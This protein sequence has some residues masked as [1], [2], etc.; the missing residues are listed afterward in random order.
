MQIKLD[1]S[2]EEIILYMFWDTEYENIDGFPNAPTF[3]S[4][5]KP[6]GAQN[7][8]QV[9]LRSR[10]T[11]LQIILCT[12]FRGAKV[13]IVVDFSIGSTWGHTIAQIWENSLK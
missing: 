5:W 12:I 9:L 2:Q 11:Y 13:E 8:D 1:R 7:S 4:S 6:P 3:E 10:F